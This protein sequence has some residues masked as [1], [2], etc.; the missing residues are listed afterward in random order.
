M[1]LR[2]VQPDVTRIDLGDGEWIEV[3]RE[4]TAGEQRRAM[5]SMIG[6]IDLKGSVTPNLDMLG[7]AEVLAYLV[8][9]SARDAADKPVPLTEDALDALA[10]ASYKA[11]AEAVEA[12]IKNAEAHAGKAA[13]ATT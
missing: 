4:L 1:K 9:W 3:K 8:D 10:P 7:K 12:H 2:F 13:T 6:R 5:T 11:I